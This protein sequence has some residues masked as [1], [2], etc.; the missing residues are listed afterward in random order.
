MCDFS[1]LLLFAFFHIFLYS[2]NFLYSK[3]NYCQIQASF[4]SVV[5]CTNFIA[6]KSQILFLHIPNILETISVL[7]A[8]L[9]IYSDVKI[10]TF[11]GV[12][13]FF[14]FYFIFYVLLIIFI[15]SNT[16]YIVP[17]SLYRL[18]LLNHVTR[19]G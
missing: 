1:L 2:F 10:I 8:R 13:S 14:P 17:I 12:C 15:T 11:L 16:N 4:C 19:T 7:N 3:K 9:A 5:Y 18:L 6:P